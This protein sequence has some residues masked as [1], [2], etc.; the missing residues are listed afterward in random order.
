MKFP[1]PGEK[2]PYGGI[3]WMISAAD[4]LARFTPER[5][6]FFTIRMEAEPGR[7]NLD[8]VW[9]NRL[10]PLAPLLN[11]SIRRDF[12]TF[13]PVWQC[14]SAELV[15]PEEFA[16]EE[17]EK[18]P[19]RPLN[20]NFECAHCPE[21]KTVFFKFSHRLFDGVGAEYFLNSLFGEGKPEFDFPVLPDDWAKIRRDGRAAGCW[22]LGMRKY[23]ICMLP[24]GFGRKNSFRTFE[25]TREETSRMQE[26]CER[27]FGPFSFSLALFGTVL[28]CM[29]RLL[30]ERG[31]RGD[32]LMIPMSVDMRRRDSLGKTPWFNRWSMLPVVVPRRDLSGT[33]SAFAAVRKAYLDGMEKNLPEIFESASKFVRIFPRPLAELALAASPR[34]SGGTMMFSFLPG[35]LHAH[36]LGN[37]SP[38]IARCVH[39]PVMPPL[40]GPGVFANLFEGRLGITVSGRILVPE[41]AEALGK[42]LAE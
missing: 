29:E 28:V 32:S 7:E 1:V 11:G 36:S 6:N 2:I 10:S 14:G 30:K 20:S 3:D 19:L 26:V 25:F 21:R 22:R 5:G 15:P 33:D 42:E 41:L 39:L 35:A 24:F 9:K 27:R 4:A 38:E 40:S 12:R 17:C 37:A 13:L 18:F 34:C 31:T 8:A 16:P 23:R